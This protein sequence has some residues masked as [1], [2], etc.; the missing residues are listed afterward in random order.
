MEEEGIGLETL[1]SAILVYICSLLTCPIAD[2]GTGVRRVS[3]WAQ[4]LF[5]C[6]GAEGWGFFL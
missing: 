6:Q 4:A 2:R 3:T 1:F 5:A